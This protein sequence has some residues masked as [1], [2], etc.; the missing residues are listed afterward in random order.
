[1]TLFDAE[2]GETLTTDCTLLV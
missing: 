2:N 1:L